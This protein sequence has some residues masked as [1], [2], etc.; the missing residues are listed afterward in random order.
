LSDDW[1]RRGA[2]L[3]IAL[4]KSDSQAGDSQ[5]AGAGEA[6]AGEAGEAGAHFTQWGQV[7]Q[8]PDLDEALEWLQPH[9]AAEHER[10]PKGVQGSLRLCHPVVPNFSMHIR[11]SVSQAGEGIPGTRQREEDGAIGLAVVKGSNAIALGVRLPLFAPS[12]CPTAAFP[13]RGPPT[14]WATRPPPIAH[15]PPP[16]HQAT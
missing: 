14:A 15:P 12:P 16:S 5:K 13:P 11:M 6:G 10:M 4:K 3:R 9:W 1:L 2:L 7:R 8:L